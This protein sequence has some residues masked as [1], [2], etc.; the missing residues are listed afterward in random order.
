M[1]LLTLKNGSNTA[2]QTKYT[3][4]VADQNQTCALC[5]LHYN[6][7]TLAFTLQCSRCL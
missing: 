4:S 6:A 1:A 2:G 7:F 3:L 5:I